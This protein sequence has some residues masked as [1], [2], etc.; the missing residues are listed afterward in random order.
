MK[1]IAMS[2]VLKVFVFIDCYVL[3]IK[4]IH[5]I[6]FVIKVFKCVGARSEA[7][8]LIQKYKKI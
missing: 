4:L 5:I 3:V 1:H 2:A 8:C 6:F 7:V